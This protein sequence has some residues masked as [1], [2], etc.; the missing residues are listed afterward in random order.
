MKKK[1]LNPLDNVD[2]KSKLL[3]CLV[4][5]L[6]V[7]FGFLCGFSVSS[8]VVS[9]SARELYDDDGVFYITFDSNTVFEFT[10]KVD[11]SLGSGFS[12]YGVRSAWC[13]VTG[14]GAFTITVYD[15]NHDSFFDINYECFDNDS[16]LIL[17]SP[18]LHDDSSSNAN[19]YVL[20]LEMVSTFLES[21]SSSEF[22]VRGNGVTRFQSQSN[23]VNVHYVFSNS[24]RDLS[25]Y[26]TDSVYVCGS[27]LPS[28]LYCNNISI[29]GVVYYDYRLSLI[30]EFYDVLNKQT[31]YR[32]YYLT[33]RVQTGY[34]N[35]VLYSRFVDNV[36]Y[37][38]A[39]NDGRSYGYDVGY[40][41]GLADGREDTLEDI[42]ADSFMLKVA[43]TF[44]AIEIFPHVRL[45]Y[46]LYFAF[47]IMLLTVV[48]Q[49][50]R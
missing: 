26:Y 19:F 40:L 4:L 24:D 6:A 7:L 45:S 43:N 42:T 21:G 37:N 27:H 15:L 5:V 36:S 16:Y 12:V 2:R 3:T 22:V 50:L 10:D 11:I 32:R 44:M 34:R 47:G 20:R 33:D 1:Q 30:I 23:N 13:V 49:F 29:V 48:T 17:Q 28:Y 35:V 8:C 9:A 39:F 14:S 41:Q 38:S 31:E 18:F 25:F 46:L